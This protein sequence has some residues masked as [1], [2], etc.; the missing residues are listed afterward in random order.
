MKEEEARSIPGGSLE[1]ARN[2]PLFAPFFSDASRASEPRT[3]IIC[4]P[5]SGG[6]S[7]EKGVRRGETAEERY[8][9]AMV[10]PVREKQRAAWNGNLGESLA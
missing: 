7:G 5:S 9:F 6:H 1:R 4:S 2:F 3:R 8:E 10:K